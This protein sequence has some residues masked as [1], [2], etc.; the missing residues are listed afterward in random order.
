MMQLVV[1]EIGGED[2]RRDTMNGKEYLV[3]P[4]R[5]IKAMRLHKGYVPKRHVKKSAPAWNGT[6]LT[7]NHPRNAE[8]ELV[9]ANSPDIA[10]KTWLGYVFNS[11]PTD[12]AVDGE[13]W[14]DIEN[15]KEIG[16]Q[17]K[18]ILNKL[19]NGETVSVSSSY[20]G[21]P[22]GPG[23]YDGEHR[24]KVRGNLRPDHVAVL[25]NKEGV[26]SID[27]GCG[28]GQQ[29]ANSELMVGASDDSVSPE[30]GQDEGTEDTMDDDDL[31]VN[32]LIGGLVFNGVTEDPPDL[33]KLP[34]NEQHF[35]FPDEPSFP[36]V[37]SEG[38]L[39]RASVRE[40]FNYREHA[41]DEDKLLSVLQAANDEFDDPPISDDEFEKAESG[42]SGVFS[43]A[44]E[45]LGLDKYIGEQSANEPA[46]SGEEADSIMGDKTQYLVENHDFDEENLP[47]E[48]S[49]CFER[50]YN[51]FDE[52]DEV[53]DE[54]PDE[55]SSNGV[56][57]EQLA[58]ALEDRF[59][60][61][62]LT[63]DDLE[64]ALA[65]NE[66]RSEKEE[67]ADDIIANSDD[68]EEDDREE[69]VGND[70]EVLESLASNVT[71]SELG[72]DRRGNLGAS[73]SGGSGDDDVSDW[74]SPVANER[75]AEIE[76]AD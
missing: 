41:P 58:N 19:K 34:E 76:E 44:L 49:E 2:V 55:Q 51:A 56:D 32:K 33:D 67:L 71:E 43:N 4:I 62:F 22:L 20:F 52:E 18:L 12:S 7:L 48:D 65:A 45:F 53:E 50:I 64:E 42:S 59:E 35:V 31:T 63:E 57:E 66:E 23:E 28:V 11:K 36:L 37:D 27:E 74:P 75:Q 47:P 39:S 40:A 70:K 17:A 26:C 16:G 9:S 30:T 29:V 21:D 6:P 54:T 13:A 5:L 69:L 14:L 68:W 46:E 38:R 25:P 10:E 73:A 24:D 60:D 15:A 72:A 8:G 1:N 61:K 3:A